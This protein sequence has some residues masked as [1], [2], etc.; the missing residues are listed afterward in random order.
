MKPRLNLVR[1]FA[2]GMTG[3]TWAGISDAAALDYPTRPVRWIVGY[4]AGG[5]TDIGGWAGRRRRCHVTGW[6]G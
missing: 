4:P 1:L 6:P 2:L 3:L 5:S